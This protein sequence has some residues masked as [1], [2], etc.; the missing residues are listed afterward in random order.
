MPTQLNL[1]R[2]FSLQFQ[3]HTF[4]LMQ[5]CRC[6]N[7]HVFKFRTHQKPLNQTLTV[8]RKWKSDK[9]I[10]DGKKV[11]RNDIVDGNGFPVWEIPITHIRVIF[12]SLRKTDSPFDMDKQIQATSDNTIKNEWQVAFICLLIHTITHTHAPVHTSYANLFICFVARRAPNWQ[13]RAI[14]NGQ[15]SFSGLITMIWRD[16]KVQT[17][18]NE[19]ITLID[20]QVLQSYYFRW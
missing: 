2:I 4:Y 15:H 20:C 5:I 11:N 1:L 19:V 12:G 18:R 6:C 9:S 8:H 10:C 17:T 7:W 3:F 16:F 13:R 14:C